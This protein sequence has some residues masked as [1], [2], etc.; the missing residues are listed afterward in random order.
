MTFTKEKMEFKMP[1]IIFHTLNSVLEWAMGHPIVKLGRVS[2]TNFKNVRHGSIEM[3]NAAGRSAGIIALYGQNG[4]GKTSFIN[5]IGVLKSCLV[6]AGLPLKAQT[7]IE[8]GFPSA[9]IEYVFRIDDGSRAYRA[10]Y[11]VTLSRRAA[12]SAAE[13]PESQRL[14][15]VFISREVLKIAVDGEASSGRLRTAIDTGRGDAF[16]PDT[17]LRQFVGDSKEAF[18]DLVVARRVTQRESRSFIFSQELDEFRK[19]MQDRRREGVTSGQPDSML[20]ACEAVVEALAFYG[21]DGLF[22]IETSLVDSVGLSALPLVFRAD[23]SNG[24]R[25]SGHETLRADVP[26]NI[27]EKQLAVTKKI[28]SSLNIV[29]RQI[30]PGLEIEIRE[31][32]KVVLED[33]SDGQRVQLLSKRGDVVLPLDCESEGIKKIISVLQVLILMYN[34]PSVTVAID[35]LDSGIFEY[36]LGELLKIIAEGGRGQLIFTSHNLRPL[37]TL[38][39]QFV[40]FTSTDPDNRYVRMKGAKESNNLRSMYFRSIVL[41]GSPVELYEY[42]SNGEIAYA[43]RQAGENIE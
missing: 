23:T 7:F 19:N 17:M 33:G 18:L 12:G 42:T 6:G 27:P 15:S 13:T 1:N 25:I 8:F 5:A 10:V 38:D 4:S 24:E 14:P 16:G 34:E 41:G 26:D 37:E 20:D 2:L 11:E 39:K 28:V 21:V 31:L 32:G 36:L 29:L 22:V 35:E 43:M 3:R 9:T 30:V 40:V